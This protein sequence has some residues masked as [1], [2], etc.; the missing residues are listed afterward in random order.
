MLVGLWRWLGLF[1]EGLPVARIGAVGVGLSAVWGW[2]W[3]A[4]AG[5]ATWVGDVRAAGLDVVVSV[6]DALRLDV[7]RK[8][9]WRSIGLN[10]SRGV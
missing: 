2:R 7:L 1:A 10:Y 5:F 3:L 8:S 4:R 6:A 9:E